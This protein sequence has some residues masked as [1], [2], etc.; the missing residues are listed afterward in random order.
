MA[1]S[2]KRAWPALAFFAGM[3][4]KMH[5]TPQQYLSHTNALDP[6]REWLEHLARIALQTKCGFQRWRLVRRT[7][8]FRGVDMVDH[9]NSIQAGSTSTGGRC[10]ALLLC[11]LYQGAPVAHNASTAVAGMLV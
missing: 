6:V 11:V 7:A 8:F 2:R 9:A 10:T 1:N 5:E 4:Q 3:R